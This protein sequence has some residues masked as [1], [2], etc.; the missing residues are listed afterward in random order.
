M[1]NQDFKHN[2]EFR[3]GAQQGFQHYNTVYN[4]TCHD[5]GFNMYNT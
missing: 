4:I 1:I 3:L 5:K 2:C